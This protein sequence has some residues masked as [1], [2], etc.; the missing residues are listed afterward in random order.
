M[1]DSSDGR[2]W[3]KTWSQLT[4][5]PSSSEDPSVIV[6]FEDDG[7]IAVN[8][9]LCAASKVYAAGSVAKYPNSRT[10]NSTIAGEGTVDGVEAGRVAA[11]NM[12]HEYTDRNNYSAFSNM[13]QSSSS[14][15]SIESFASTSVPVWRSDITAY[16]GL[17]KPIISSLPGL[18]IQA[19]CIGNCD[20]ERLATRGFWWTNT[21]AFRKA[22]RSMSEEEGGE[23]EDDGIING[24]NSHGGTNNISSTNQ[25]LDG[26][27]LV[28]RFTGRRRKN[29]NGNGTVTPIYGTGVVYYLDN[30]GRVRGILTW[31]LP[32]AKQVGGPMNVHLLSKLKHIIVSNAGVS[33]L[34]AEEN[35][36]IMNNALAR[37]SQ[38]LVSI[39]VKGDDDDDD[40]N[41]HSST[42]LDFAKRVHGLDGPIEGY[43]TPLYRFTEV[44]QGMNNKSVSV[45]KRKEGGNHGLLGEDLYARDEHGIEQE[46]QYSE[47][48]DGLTNIPQ[49]MY[50]ITVVPF[51]VEATYGQKAA[52]LASLVELNRYL[53]IQRGWE[54]NENRARPGKED[55]LWLRPG[56][57]RKNV[58]RKQIIIDTY[59]QIL[60]PHRYN[61]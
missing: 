22:T 3:Y 34:D 31:G 35:H 58:S 48:E 28:S 9:E 46:T 30:N 47:E 13:Q 54:E 39:A 6:C 52:S 14:H 51:Q 53:A 49:T 33:A 24:S 12:S 36:Q 38:K 10:G 40:D 17:G 50:P 18:G 5:N 43:S 23:E 26:A 29:N 15:E 16:S 42:L 61:Q 1:L 57:E 19:L 60:F 45:L 4:K 59:K 56:D 2:P 7:R 55:P 8:T 20:S 37:C 27:R 21:S 25:N 32:F 44:A 41:Q 11:I